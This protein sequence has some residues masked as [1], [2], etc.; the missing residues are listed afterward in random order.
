MRSARLARLRSFLDTEG[1]LRL[2]RTLELIASDTQEQGGSFYLSLWLDDETQS[3]CGKHK[4]KV[5]DLIEFID[6]EGT[7]RLSSDLRF[8]L[9]EIFWRADCFSDYCR[10][11]DI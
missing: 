8:L 9:A 11:H 10:Q 7:L 6:S 5:Y 2:S 3:L 1:T 4:F